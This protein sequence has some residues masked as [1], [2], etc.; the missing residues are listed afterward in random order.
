[1]SGYGLLAK[2]MVGNLTGIS[3]GEGPDRLLPEI[4]SGLR[5][6]RI[7]KEILRAFSENRDGESSGEDK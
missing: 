5:R 2:S 3:T 4:R 6:E 7:R 1:M